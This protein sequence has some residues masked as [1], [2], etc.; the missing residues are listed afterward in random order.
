MLRNEKG[1]TLI[2]LVMII[3]ILGIL[4]AIA[5]PKYADLAQESRNAVLDASV[6]AVKSAAIIQYAQSRTS[7]L[8]A[9]IML[10][11]ELD[12]AVTLNGGSTCAN[13][14]LTHSGGGSRAFSISSTY[15]SG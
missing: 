15:C 1:F 4:A 13:A 6:G 2:E 9:S 10:Q 12:A 8:L 5:L 7:T 14:T 11:T 3:V